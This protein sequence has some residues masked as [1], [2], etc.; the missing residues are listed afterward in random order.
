M[1][2]PINTGWIK[3][4][5]EHGPALVFKGCQGVLREFGHSIRVA[6]R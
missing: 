6:Y 2:N 3:K 5:S 4:S 1:E